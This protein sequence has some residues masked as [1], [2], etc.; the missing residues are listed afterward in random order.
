MRV[1]EKFC[2]KPSQFAP[3]PYDHYLKFRKKRIKPR[4]RLWFCFWSSPN[5]T[6]NLTRNLL[7]AAPYL[8]NLGTPA[9][10]TYKQKLLRDSKI[11]F[12]LLFF[13][14][15]YFVDLFLLLPIVNMTTITMS[16]KHSRPAAPNTDGIITSVMLVADS[17]V[18]ES[19]VML[20]VAWRYVVVNESVKFLCDTLL[21]LKYQTYN[22][23]FSKSWWG[24]TIENALKFSIKV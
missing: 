10:N 13:F 2:K 11:N 17:V 1:S 16:E 9:L 6:S 19:C 8:K 12:S 20:A 22:K 14:Y 3:I 4:R 24:I 18:P 5:F 7:T 15:W 21:V 23:I